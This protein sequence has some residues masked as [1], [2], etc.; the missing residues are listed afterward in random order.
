MCTH[1]S[2]NPLCVYDFRDDHFVLAKHLE[3]SPLGEANSPS[4]NSHESSVVL[5]LEWDSM[6]FPFC[7]SMSIG[8]FE[9]L[10]G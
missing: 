2:L 5:C 6:R 10:M 1:T 4:L 8:I 3:V 9:A 7:I